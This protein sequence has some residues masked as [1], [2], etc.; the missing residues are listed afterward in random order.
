MDVIG[1]RMQFD[2]SKFA[3]HLKAAKA[4]H[5]MMWG[6]AWTADYPDGD[7]FMQ[8]LYGPNTN[9]S[10]NACARIP[11][12]DR[13]YAR[14][15]KMPPGAERDKLYREMTRVIEAYAPWR[16]MISRYRNMLVQPHV[17]GYKRH[18]ILHAHWQYLDVAPR[19]PN[20]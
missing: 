4:C 6:A 1:I 20:K 9:Q 2:I 5:L 8:L 11:E 15:Q 16:L 12:F 17:L 18:P 10:N 14:A 13:L 7:N 19:G 3:D